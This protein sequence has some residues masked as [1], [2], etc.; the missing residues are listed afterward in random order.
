MIPAISCAKAEPV[1][2]EV[3]VEGMHC[4]SCADAIIDALE[5][6]EGIISATSDFSTGITTAVHD[7]KHVKEELIK[8]TIE[9][10]GYTVITG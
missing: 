9:D 6:I 10:L 5:G 2:T 3:T 8:T 1:T 4:Q 7:P